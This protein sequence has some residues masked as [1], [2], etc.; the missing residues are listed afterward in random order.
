MNDT[1]HCFICKSPTQVERMLDG[2]DGYTVS[3]NTCGDYIISRT[4]ASV[5]ESDDYNEVRYKFSGIV[6]NANEKVVINSENFKHWIEAS[7]FPETPIEKMDKLMEYLQERS[8]YIGEDV[9]FNLQNDYPIAF[10]KNEKELEFLLETLEERG[11]VKGLGSV[12]PKRTFRLT[13]DGWERLSDLK[14]RRI[15]QDKVFVAM[16]FDKTMDE[17]WEKGFKEAIEHESVASGRLKAVRI[18]RIP[19]N[20]KI[21]NRIEAEIPECGFLVADQTGHRTGVYYEAGIAKGLGMPVIWTCKEE[22]FKERE[23]DFD[24]RQYS[25]IKW[26][27]PDDL[28]EQLIY[29]IKATILFGQE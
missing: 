15:Q 14:H 22:Y 10:A 21:C 19:H 26:T 24:T 13:G 16:W 12:T 25:T 11:L 8:R 1:T 6:R 9:R 29:H 7:D 2:L 27:D 5:L 20:D 28:K 18:D 17:A 3:C 23:K 4:A